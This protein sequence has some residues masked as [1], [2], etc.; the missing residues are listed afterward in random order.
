MSAWD[1]V[2]RRWA[3]EAY[4]AR[5]RAGGSETDGYG[6]GVIVLCEGDAPRETLPAL[7]ARELAAFRRGLRPAADGGVRE[8][9]FATHPAAGGPGHAYA[10]LVAVPPDKAYSSRHFLRRLHA[11]ACEGHAGGD[12]ADRP[13]GGA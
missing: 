4:E 9:A 6:P 5:L 8:L 11:E 2:A 1:D 10:L 13:E 3:R 7:G 12:E